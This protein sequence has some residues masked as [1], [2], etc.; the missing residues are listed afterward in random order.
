MLVRAYA[1]LRLPVGHR[2]GVMHRNAAVGGALVDR[3]PAA[4]TGMTADPEAEQHQQAAGHI[5]EVVQ[6]VAEPTE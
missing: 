2:Q 5:R 6:S 1:V 4:G 3:Y